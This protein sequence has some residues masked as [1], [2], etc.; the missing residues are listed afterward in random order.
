LRAEHKDSFGV[1]KGGKEAEEEERPTDLKKDLEGIRRG[2]GE[3]EA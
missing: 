3:L 2:K 1:N